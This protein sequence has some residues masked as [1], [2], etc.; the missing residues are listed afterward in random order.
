M[1]HIPDFSN[2]TIV[3]IGDVI[4]D[5]YFWGDVDRISPEAPV[6]VVKVN[7]KTMNLGGAGNVAMNLKGLNCGHMLI[8]LRGIDAN[9]AHLIHILENTLAVRF[10][11]P[12]RNDLF[13]KVFTC[14]L[15]ILCMG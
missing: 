2:R 12:E 1:T 10:S 11:F 9:G 13:L 15:C 8:G 4:L 14:I 5:Q 3:V 7:Q 6:P